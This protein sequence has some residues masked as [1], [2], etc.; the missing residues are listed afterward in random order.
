MMRLSGIV[1]DAS[2]L[3]HFIKEDL[4]RVGRRVSSIPFLNL[5]KLLH[6]LGFEEVLLLLDANTHHHFTRK[7][8]DVLAQCVQEGRV[9]ITPHYSLGPTLVQLIGDN[10]HYFL[11][12]NRFLDCEPP[13]QFL[14]RQIPYVICNGLIQFLPVEENEFTFV[15]KRYTLYHVLSP[16]RKIEY[17]EK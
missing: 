16:M 17:D 10:G 14:R 15:G 1:V 8:R 4:R 5:Q 2:N 3:Y 13:T 11:S 7:E 9:Q 6:H 12:R